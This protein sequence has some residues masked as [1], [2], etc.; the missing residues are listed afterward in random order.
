MKFVLWLL[1][2]IL[3]IGGVVQLFQG[4]ILLAALLIVVGLGVG[5]GGFTFFNSR[6][7][8]PSRARH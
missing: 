7:S 4:Q 6:S 3:V 8:H 1:A 5:P 2:A